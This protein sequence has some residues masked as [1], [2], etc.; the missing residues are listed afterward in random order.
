MI[1]LLQLLLLLLIRDE[2][3]SRRYGPIASMFSGRHAQAA[4][5]LVAVDPWSVLR[6][7]RCQPEPPLPGAQPLGSNRPLSQ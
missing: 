5:P 3:Q 2:V 7:A 6:Q 4:R 1:L